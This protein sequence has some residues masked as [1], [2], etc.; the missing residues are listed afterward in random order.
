MQMCNVLIIFASEP[1]KPAAVNSGGKR[2]A[3]TKN[4][5][6]WERLL[7]AGQVPVM[8]YSVGY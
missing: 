2:T 4:A 1:E 5:P 7:K 3:Q 8:L 6:G